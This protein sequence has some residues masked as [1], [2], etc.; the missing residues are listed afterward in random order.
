MPRVLIIAYG[1]PLRGD[2]GIAWRAADLLEEK[3]AR[4]EVEILRTHQLTPEVAES[5]TRVEAVIFVDAAFADGITAQPGEI[6]EASIV[7]T[8]ET[9][10]FSHHLSPGA[11]IALA[12]DLYGVSPRASCVTLAGQS[13]DHGESLSPAVAAALPAFVVRIEALVQQLLSS[14]TVP[15]H[16]NKP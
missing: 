4:S 8:K 11:V 7:P 9:P 2:D 5:A 14:K 10:S 13:F 16:C 12:R 1:N 3:F 6:R 15:T